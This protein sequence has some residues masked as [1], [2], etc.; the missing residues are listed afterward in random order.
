M[1]IPGNLSV[2]SSA[3]NSEILLAVVSRPLMMLSVD[4]LLI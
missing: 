2:R 3:K 4:S 1:D